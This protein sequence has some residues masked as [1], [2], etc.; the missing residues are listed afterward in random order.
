MRVARQEMILEAAEELLYQRSFDGVGIDEIG[1][2]AGITGGAVYRH[3]GSKGEILAALF[4]RA[5]D[6]LL[7]TIGDVRPDPRE[8]LAALIAAHVEFATSHRQLAG[9]WAREERSLTDPYRRSYHRRQRRYLDRWV[10]CMTLC[11]PQRSRAEILTA[12]AGIHALL[13]SDAIRL[14]TRRTAAQP[15]LAAMAAASLNALEMQP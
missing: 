7:V 3:F 15:L 13:T 14:S 4:D 12:M 1:R 5:I 2:R 8:E 6:R 9:I 11:Y 10:N